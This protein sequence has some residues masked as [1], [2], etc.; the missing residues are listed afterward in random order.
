MDSRFRGSDRKDPLLPF[1][2][3]RVTFATFN[4]QMKWPSFLHL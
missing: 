2:H 1:P 4:L 3:S